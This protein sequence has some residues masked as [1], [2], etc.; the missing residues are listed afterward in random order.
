MAIKRIIF[1]V[2]GERD[3]AMRALQY[4]AAI[5]AAYIAYGA[6]P[7]DKEKYIACWVRVKFFQRVMAEQAEIF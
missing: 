3:N 5:L 6:A 4:R 7:I 1:L 2:I